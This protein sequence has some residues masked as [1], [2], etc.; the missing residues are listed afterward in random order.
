MTP[1]TTTTA[2]IITAGIAGAVAIVK[3]LLPSKTRPKPD[4]ITRAEFHDEQISTRDRISANYLALADKLDAIHRDLLA[5]LERFEHRLDQ[6]ESNF[7]RLDI[8]PVST[9]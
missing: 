8:E 4:Y 6:L 3:K 9:R 5:A 2:A 1:T 7:A